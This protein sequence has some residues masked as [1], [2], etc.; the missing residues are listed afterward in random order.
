MEGVFGSS[1]LVE[2]RRVDHCRTAHEPNC[3]RRSYALSEELM[4]LERQTG[5]IGTREVLTATEL[6]RTEMNQLRDRGLVRCQLLHEQACCEKKT[7]DGWDDVR[8]QDPNE[9]ASV[10]RDL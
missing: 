3:L 5:R 6:T 9:I 10:G 8:H 7:G 1:L 2:N 4:D